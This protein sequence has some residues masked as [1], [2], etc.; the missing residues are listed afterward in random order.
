MIVITS[1]DY[2][3]TA[4]ITTGIHDRTLSFHASANGRYDTYLVQTSAPIVKHLSMEPFE[5][6]VRGSLYGRLVAWLSVSHNTLSH[7]S[8][9]TFTDQPS[10]HTILGQPLQRQPGQGI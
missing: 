3:S 4:I 6:C 8:C 10:C 1:S 9:H 5:L 7:R 2:N